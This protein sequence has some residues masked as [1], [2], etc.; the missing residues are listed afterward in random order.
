MVAVSDTLAQHR[1]MTAQIAKC[2]GPT[3]GAHLGPVGPRWAPYWPH[4][5]CYQIG[6]LQALWGTESDPMIQIVATE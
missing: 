5:P 2:M 6:L 1:Y 4:E 3:Y